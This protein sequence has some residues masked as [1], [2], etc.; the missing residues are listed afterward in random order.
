MALVTRS[1]HSKLNTLFQVLRHP[2][3]YFQSVTEGHLG[4]VQLNIPAA[5][6]RYF[7]V[8][9]PDFTRFIYAHTERQFRKAPFVYNIV[10]SAIG[11]GILTSSGELWSRQRKLVNH[12]FQPTC[13]NQF[14][15]VILEAVDNHMLAW[16][17][18]IANSGRI[19]ISEQMTRIT[20]S[21]ILATMFSTHLQ[22]DS[23]EISRAVLALNKDCTRKIK[24]LFKPPLWFPSPLNRRILKNRKV[25]ERVVTRIISEKQSNSADDL[26]ASLMA[27]LKDQ[28]RQALDELMTIFLGGH[29]TTSSLLTYTLF[30]IA[31]YPAVQQHIVR[32][33]GEIIGERDVRFSDL[34]DFTYLPKVINESIRLYTP[35]ISPVRTC[36]E[37][38]SY[39]GEHFN[40]GDNFFLCHWAA[41][42]NAD[43]W[44]DPLTFNPDRFSEYNLTAAQKASFLPF[45]AGPRICIGKKLS[46]IEAQVII[47]KMLQRYQIG[48]IDGYELDINRNVTSSARRPLRATLN[49]RPTPHSG[50]GAYRSECEEPLP[51]SG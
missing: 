45:G 15:Q 5:L 50:E 2:E 9:D 37:S 42:N 31:K 6:G 34:P 8:T 41:N 4:V 39:E 17:S 1:R 25:V 44:P 22:E 23:E 14:E 38:F 36:T 12:Y 18:R 16:Q 30:C 46:M 51:E 24:S 10:K 11:N 48:L 21:I 28:P 29:E 32:E 26:A 40:S 27:E 13:I 19:N 33:I 3:E 20:M 43:L 49:P 47:I 35:I 7:F